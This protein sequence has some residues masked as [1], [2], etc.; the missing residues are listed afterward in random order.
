MFN[1]LKSIDLFSGAGGMTEG[2][3]SCGFAPLYANDFEEPALETF[4]ENHPNCEV[5]S[6][7]IE[8]VDAK[9]IRL[10]LKLQKRELDVL[11]GGPPC[12]G[13]STYGQRSKSDYRNQLYK[14][15]LR[16]IKEF[17]PRVFVMENVVG[18]LSMENGEVVSEITRQMIE[19]GYGV[20]MVVLNAQEFGVPQFRKRVFFLGA[21]DN[22]DI[23]CPVPTHQQYKQHSE[24]T[25]FDNELPQSLTVR[26]AISDLPEQA[27]LPAQAHCILEYPNKKSMGTRY[28]QEIRGD[29][30]GILNHSAKQMLGIRKLRVALLRPG[31]YGTQLKQR[32]LQDGL[33]DE[34]IDNLLGG[35]GL[36]EVSKCRKQDREKEAELRKILRS[37]HVD[38]EKVLQRLDANGFANKYRRLQ[39]DQPSHTVCCSYGQRL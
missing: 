9:E 4:S 12:Q 10:L 28:Q 25:L 29:S 11:V 32:L 8:E 3:K 33:S 18:I 5:S 31:D 22:G 24:Y 30:K 38:I 27:L 21:R 1:K 36:A 14:H 19:L 6:E 7:S 2:L 35:H 15:F 23:A 20:R 17:Q 34:L 37:G 13:F 39:W 26:C 16:F